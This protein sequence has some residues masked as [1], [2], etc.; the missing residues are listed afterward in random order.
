MRA[1]CS[2]PRR[3]G[4]VALAALALISVTAL[5]V[6]A[7]GAGQAARELLAF[8]F[9]G[10]PRESAAALQVA[11]SNLRLVAGALL[12]AWAVRTRPQLRLPLDLTLAA[13]VALNS[14]VVG[15]ALGA[16]GP[17]LLKALV[18]HGPLELAAFAL[19]GGAYLAARAGEL[20]S[21]RLAAAAVV[22]CLL[23]AAGAVVETYVQIGAGS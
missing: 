5:L 17:R 7:L 23:I 12:A 19:A 4:Q 8:R 13:V 2:L 15:G 21:G 3:A 9:A 10:P 18:L 6:R 1:T 16:Y 22:A 11:A 14:A 20:P